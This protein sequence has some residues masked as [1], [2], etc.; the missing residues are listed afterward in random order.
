MFFGPA[1]R[2]PFPLAKSWPCL[3]RTRLAG[4]ETSAAVVSTVRPV[5]PSH[6][7][8]EGERHEYSNPA[9]ASVSAF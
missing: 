4:R 3:I 7:N 1:S 8:D 2:L 5:K 9:Q 6:D